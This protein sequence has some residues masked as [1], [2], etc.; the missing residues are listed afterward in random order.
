MCSGR[1]PNKTSLPAWLRKRAARASG[2][3]NARLFER[4]KLSPLPFVSSFTGMKFIAGDEFHS[5]KAGD[6]RQ[7][8]ELASFKQPGISGAGG[9]RRPLSQPCRQGRL[10][11][12]AAGA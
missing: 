7:R 5:G 10:V 1:K 4:R 6:E 11:R 2:T 12:L 9:S 3:G 8:A